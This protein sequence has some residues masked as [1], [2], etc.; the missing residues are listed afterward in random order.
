[1]ASYPPATPQPTLEDW[2]VWVNQ[3]MG[4]PSIWLPPT[5][6]AIPLAY[7]L[8]ISIV[9]PVFASVPGPIYQQMVFNLAGHLLVTYAQDVT[10]K[11]P[12]PYKVVDGEPY[13]YFSY[14]RKTNN[15]TGFVTGIVQST[16]DEGTSVSLVVPES[17]KNLTMSQ[18]QL[19]TTI[20]GRTYLGFAQDWNAPWGIS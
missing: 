12:Y 8:A 13:G 4:V 16:G 9:N 15:V 17:F 6:P 5:S 18:L 2:L 1:M 14:I 11:P 3:I 10:T 19:T 20:W 7:S